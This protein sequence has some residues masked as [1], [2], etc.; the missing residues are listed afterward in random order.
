MAND[1]APGGTLRAAFLAVKQCIVVPE[2]DEA[3][4]ALLNRFIDE[5]RDAGFIQRAIA[6]AKLNGVDVAPKRPR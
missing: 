1:L 2:N 3:R 5:M 6:G 4:L